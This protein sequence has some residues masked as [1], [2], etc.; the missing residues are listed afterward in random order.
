MFVWLKGGNFQLIKTFQGHLN[1]SLFLWE[2][3]NN[4]KE[5][6]VFDNT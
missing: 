5:Q 3:V 4:I 6:M 2:F 1:N